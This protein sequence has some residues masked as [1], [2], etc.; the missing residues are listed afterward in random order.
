[1]RKYTAIFLLFLF[2]CIFVQAEEKTLERELNKLL[3]SEKVNADS[4]YLYIENW[5]NF[6]EYNEKNNFQIEHNQIN[7]TLAAPYLIFIPSNY[8]PETKTPLIIYLHGA[9]S[10]KNFVEDP[11]EMA[12]SNPFIPYSEKMGW[13]MLFPMGKINYTW[14]DKAGITNLQEQLI[15]TKRK[16][17]IDDDRVYVTGFSDGGSGSFYLG[18][19]TPNHFASFYPLNGFISVGSLV[20]NTPIYLQNLRNRPFYA[21]NTELD[22][23]YPAALMKPLMQIAVAARANLLY[24]EYTEIG[25]EFTYAEKEIPIIIKNMENNPRNKFQPALY[26]ETWNPQYGRCDWVEVIEIDSAKIS[27]EWQKEYRYELPDIRITFGF[28]IDRDYENNGIKVAKIVDGDCTAREMGLKAEDIVIK[29]NDEPV[30]ADSDLS[31]LKK[32]ISR[33]DSVTLTVKRN[34]KEIKLFGQIPDTTYYDAFLYNK[35]SGAVKAN[36]CANEFNI[37][38]S[39]IKRFALYLH[40][41]MVNFDNNVF[42]NLNGKKIFEQTIEMDKEFIINNFRKHFDRNAIWAKRLEFEVKQ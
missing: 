20:T 17:N 3:E 18:L 30:S 24:K 29:M 10:R 7:D 28:Y 11:L 41:N 27:K 35:P 5:N 25:H 14:W 15:A 39:R 12:R 38:T 9:V 16:F 36:Y 6:S 19:N 26:W 37:Y 42:I 34:S 1:M 23:L 33:G 21:I 32:N 40:P 2:C 8:N 13:F 31:R 22:Q 4:V